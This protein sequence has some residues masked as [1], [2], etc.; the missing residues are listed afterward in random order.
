MIA[1][2]RQFRFSVRTLLV[3]VT[4]LAMPLAWLSW[5]AKI[6]SDRKRA[7]DWINENLEVGCGSLALVDGRDPFETSWVREKLGDERQA[8]YIFMPHWTG[9]AKM[10]ELARLFPETHFERHPA[11]IHDWSRRWLVGHQGPKGDWSAQ[12]FHRLCRGKPC[13][14]PGSPDADTTV[15][16]AAVL[17]LLGGGSS[18][19]AGTYPENVKR[20][21]DSLVRTLKETDDR[22]DQSPMTRFGQRLGTLALCEYFGMWRDDAV[23]NVAQR[24]LQSIAAAALPES[25]HWRDAPGQATDSSIVVWE[26]LALHSGEFARLAMDH[27]ALDDRAN[28]LRE[29]VRGAE[30]TDLGAAASGLLALRVLRVSADE[31]DSRLF[32]DRLQAGFRQTG[33]RR[34]CVAMLLVGMALHPQPEAFD[35]WRS[36]LVKRLRLSQS[37]EG[38]SPGSMNP[39]E[40]TPDAWGQAGGRVFVTAMSMLSFQ[41]YY[42]HLPLFGWTRPHAAE[43]EGTAK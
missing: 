34:D 25:P 31:P 15:T 27:K 39:D 13:L 38:C 24:G 23:R 6:A 41:I 1:P 9:D 16:A 26:M 43:K 3:F 11:S 33:V 32:S 36:L 28:W 10:Q 22:S 12:D 14:S 21:L 37:R 7:R 4:V 17:S 20:G 5:Q 2:R 19:H 40:P 35:E 30:E 42:H 8:P 29:A 18:P